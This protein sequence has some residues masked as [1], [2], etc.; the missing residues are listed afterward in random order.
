[1]GQ[2]IGQSFAIG[3]LIADRIQ[4]FIRTGGLGVKLLHPLV[5]ALNCFIVFSDLRIRCR[6]LLNVRL[7][8]DAPSGILLVEPQLGRLVLLVLLLQ[9][10]DFIS[11]FLDGRFPQITDFAVLYCF[12]LSVPK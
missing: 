4:L 5:T 6:L 8:R 7:L 9:S 11:T 2:L 3:I 12:L 10:A 1:M